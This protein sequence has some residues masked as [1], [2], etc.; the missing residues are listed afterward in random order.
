MKHEIFHHFAGEQ[1]IKEMHFPAGYSLGKHVHSYDHFS[2]LI[3]G[4]A[5]LEIDGKAHE[6]AAPT[7]LKVEANCA[8]QAH[9]HEDSIWLCTHT[10]TAEQYKSGPDIFDAVLIAKEK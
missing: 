10:M 1:Y 2:I 5:T 7:I 3:K 8:H 4:S 9:F 6:I